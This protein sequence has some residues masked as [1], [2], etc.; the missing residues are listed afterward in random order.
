M[1]TPSSQVLAIFMASLL[2]NEWRLFNLVTLNGIKMIGALILIPLLM[3]LFYEK[4]NKS[5]KWS[6]LIIGLMIYL[7]AQKIF[8]KYFLN[9]VEPLQMLLFQ[10]IGAV[11][12]VSGGL[13]L[14]KHKFFVGK[15][16]ALTGLTQGLFT[17]TGVWLYYVGL[18]KSTI[19]QTVL[20]RM[21][22]FIILTTLAGLYVFK[23]VKNMTLK[24][25]LG[26]GVALVIAVLV[27]T[28]NH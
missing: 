10:Y 12:V 18:Q 23:E 25:W 1:A 16:F 21:P 20:L 6:F 28:A 27:M 3:Y 7:A 11:M 2:F 15:N 26:M 14:K 8:A 24:K 13:K 17:S 4:D 22:I 19:S 5:K 9:Q